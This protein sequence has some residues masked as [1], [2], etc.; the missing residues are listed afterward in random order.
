MFAHSYST[1][2]ITNV[3]WWKNAI[4]PAKQFSF[5]TTLVVTYDVVLTAR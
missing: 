1:K 4:R 3:L 2:A 5:Y